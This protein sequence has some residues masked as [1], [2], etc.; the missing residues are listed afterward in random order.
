M[1]SKNVL[2]ID[3]ILFIS[4]PSM[5]IESI[6]LDIRQKTDWHKVAVFRPYLRDNLA[7]YLRKGHRVLVQGKISYSQYQDSK[8]AQLQST[9]IIADDVIF[10]SSSDKMKETAEE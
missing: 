3:K 2:L 7:N 1:S 5:K 9:T 4:S 8:G 10:M 6:V